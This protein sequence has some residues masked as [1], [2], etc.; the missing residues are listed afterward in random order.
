VEEGER[1]HRVKLVVT[2]TMVESRV[3]KQQ[4]VHSEEPEKKVVRHR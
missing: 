2:G 1:N 3:E 4:Q